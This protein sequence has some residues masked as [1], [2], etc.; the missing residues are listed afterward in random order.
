VLHSRERT[1]QRRCS[2]RVVGVHKEHPTAPTDE[3]HQDAAGDTLRYRW[4]VTAG[5]PL[6]VFVERRNAEKPE[7]VDAPTDLS[8]E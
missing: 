6:V 7:P 8:I 3:E 1:G 5:E 4:P 2:F